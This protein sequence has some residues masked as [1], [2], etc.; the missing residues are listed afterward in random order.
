MKVYVL[1]RHNT[2]AQCIATRP[3]LVLCKETVQMTGAWVT[4][5]WRDQEGLD[6]V[7]AREAAETSEKEGGQNRHK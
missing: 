6:L 7:G 5:R 3:I 1:K 2:A 4:K